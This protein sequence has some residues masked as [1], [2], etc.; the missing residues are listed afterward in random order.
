MVARNKE[1][2]KDYIKNKFSDNNITLYGCNYKECNEEFKSNFSL[3]NH[4]ILKHGTS[5]G[6]I[7]CDI[8]DKK[9]KGELKKHKVNKHNIDVTWFECDI[10][11]CEYKC[12]HNSNLKAHKANK[13]NI[14]VTWYECDID[15]CDFKCKENGSLKRHKDNKHN[16]DSIWFKC[17]IDSCEYK[18]KNNS[19]LK[20]HKANKHNINIT[21]FK[22]T[23]CKY[24]CKHSSD[25]KKHKANKHNIYVTWIKCDIDK[26]D[27]KC[28]H[29]SVLKAHKANKH[30]IN[31][32]W[33]ECD[34]DKC[35]F[36]CKHNGTLK[37]HKEYKHDMGKYKCDFCNGNKNS[38]ILYKDNHGNH[39]IC[40]RCYHKWTGKESRIELRW[41]KYIDDNLGI[42]FLSSSDVNL[43]QLGGC[44]LYRP[45]KLYIG[46]TTVELD[47]CDEQQHRYGTSYLCDERRVSH[48]YDEDG[49]CGKKLI[50]IRW[51]P[52]TYKVPSGYTKKNLVKKLEMMVN[53]KK[54]LRK[55]PPKDIIHIYYMFYD[56][57]NPLITENIPHTM[58]YD[59]EDYEG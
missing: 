10:D 4:K 52:H 54:H 16:I 38:R 31:V 35:E 18:C 13:H 9:M 53:L 57:D 37:I 1:I 56:V 51:N 46:L 25:L 7:Y 29:S 19:D 28:K 22:C 2:E 6:F 39:K 44:Q 50:V 55:N 23:K 20:R 47:E 27:F 41:S 11:K 34:I 30:N 32:T 26:C 36:K 15:S 12:K 42:E 5:S 45:D 14:D 8:C 58:I 24:K 48:I 33:Y 17:D 21:W 3:E 49:I 43:R 59:K 40:K